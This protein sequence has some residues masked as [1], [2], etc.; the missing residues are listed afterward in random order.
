MPQVAACG[1]DS[2]VELFAQQAFPSRP[3]MRAWSAAVVPGPSTLGLTACRGATSLALRAAGAVHA[4]PRRA[5]ALQHARRFVFTFVEHI[6]N[7]S[8]RQSN[9]ACTRHF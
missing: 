1:A 7:V 2:D 6:G 8:S 4:K 5:P 3:W 9:W